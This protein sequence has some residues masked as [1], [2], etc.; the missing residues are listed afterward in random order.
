MPSKPMIESD[1]GTGIP[2][3]AAARNA[4]MPRRSLLAKTAVMSDPVPV[5]G[6]PRPRAS[7]LRVSS[8][9]PAAGKAPRQQPVVRGRDAGARERLAPSGHA[10][11]AHGEAGRTGEAGDAAV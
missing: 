9:P 4:P 8:L 1:L 11:A 3:S 7:S 10:G 2:R 6:A 5:G